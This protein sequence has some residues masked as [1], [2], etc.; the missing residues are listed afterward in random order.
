MC[1]L[2]RIRDAY[3]K[4]E[5]EEQFDQDELVNQLTQ[6]KE[7]LRHEYGVGRTLNE[8]LSDAI[9]AENYESRRDYAM[10]SR[11][12]RRK[13]RFKHHE[14][15]CSFYRHSACYYCSRFFSWLIDNRF[16]IVYLDESD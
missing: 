11:S 3:V 6:L 10:K 1:A 8:Q 7:S 13:G 2:D 14:S 15:G 4:V 12:G 16:H 5:A 9:A